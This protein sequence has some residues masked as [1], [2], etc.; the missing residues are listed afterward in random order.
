MVNINLTSF[1]SNH[2]MIVAKLK[3]SCKQ[4]TITVPYKVDMG[5]DG[6]IM[7]FNIFKKLFPSTAEDKTGGSKRYNHA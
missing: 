4:A 2:S 6:N 7:P 5:C 1:N 3:T